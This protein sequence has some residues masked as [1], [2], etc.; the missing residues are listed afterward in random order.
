[1]ELLR[2]RCVGVPGAGIAP[3]GAPERSTRRWKRSLKYDNYEASFECGVRRGVELPFEC[4]ERGGG[5]S[6]RS[7]KPG[8]AAT[9]SS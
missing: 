6:M 7:E 2:R 5:D 1:M 4:F 3:V 8:A 9:G